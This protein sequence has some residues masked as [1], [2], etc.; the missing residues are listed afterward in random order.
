MNDNAEP[1]GAQHP[2]LW[3]ACTSLAPGGELAKFVDDDIH[4][5]ALSTL[6]QLHKV[7][8]TVDQEDRD[9][10]LWTYWMTTTRLL[11]PRADGR[12]MFTQFWSRDRQSEPFREG[13]T[14]PIA[15]WH[16][17]TVGNA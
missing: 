13:W 3:R 14:N 16:Y 7:G 6:V 9:I 17:E 10:L 11:F 4:K 5:L 2:D 15:A 8:S 12:M 1:I